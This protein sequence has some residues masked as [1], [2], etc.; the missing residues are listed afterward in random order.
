[1]PLQQNVFLPATNSAKVRVQFLP[2]SF[3]AVSTQPVTLSLFG[4][5]LR[6]HW[7]TLRVLPGVDNIGSSPQDLPSHA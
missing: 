1:M 2:L 7:G 5:K 3:F 6:L 4:H